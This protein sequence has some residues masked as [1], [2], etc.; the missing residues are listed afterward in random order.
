MSW[1]EVY[2]GSGKRIGDGCRGESRPT[3]GLS[4]ATRSRKGFS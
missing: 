3:D 4:L 1:E 2:G